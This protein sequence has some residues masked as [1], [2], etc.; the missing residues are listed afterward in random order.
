MTDRH[1]WHNTRDFIR[2]FNKNR[3]PFLCTLPVA[4]LISHIMRLTKLFRH[5]RTALVQPQKFLFYKSSW[6]SRVTGGARRLLHTT[7]PKATLFLT[8]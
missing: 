5:N 7:L 6:S 3:R 1:F 2:I 8:S 4:D